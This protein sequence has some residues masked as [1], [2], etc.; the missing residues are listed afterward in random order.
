M[1]SNWVYKLLF[2]LSMDKKTA[3]RFNLLRLLP[4]EKILLS[5]ESTLIILQ[6]LDKLLVF[7]C[8]YQDPLAE[9]NDQTILR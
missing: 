3:V 7:Q 5:E 2:F 1:K 8:I 6:A 4:Y 9:V